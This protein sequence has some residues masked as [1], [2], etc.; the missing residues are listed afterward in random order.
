[1]SDQIQLPDFTTMSKDEILA[2]MARTLEWAGAV[3]SETPKVESP[4]P[5][6]PTKVA[7]VRLP[8]A[9]IEDFDRFAEEDH[10]DRTA[11]M[12][13][14]LADYAERRRAA[15]GTSE[16]KIT[17]LTASTD[18]TEEILTIVESVHDRWFAHGRIDWEDFI[19]RMNGAA[20]KDGSVIDLGS[21]MSSPAIKAVIAHVR[22]YR[23][24]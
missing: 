5:G 22:T 2:W 17:V 20:L 14:A 1:M 8:A 12:R 21:D 4:T 18:V 13:R 11:V 24:W 16:S 23:R 3:L 19:H 7:A 10:A 15:G 9:L 6:P